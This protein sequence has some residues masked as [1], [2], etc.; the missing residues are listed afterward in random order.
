MNE[1]AL[2]ARATVPLMETLEPDEIEGTVPDDEDQADERA[3]FLQ[4]FFQSGV[5]Y[6]E[7]CLG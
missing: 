2:A 4:D 7:V 1:S 5:H 3:A 6:T